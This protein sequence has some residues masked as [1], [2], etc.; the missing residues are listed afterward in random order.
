VTKKELGQLFYLERE[1]KFLE[2]QL[3]EIESKSTISSSIAGGATGQNNIT[4]KVGNIATKLADYQTLICLTIEKLYHQKNMTEKYIE[5]LDDCQLRL[6][7][8]M[9]FIKFY[10][11]GK[12]AH[13]IRANGE[14]TPR[15]IVERF[16]EEVNDVGT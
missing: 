4:D 7:L 2:E 16:F 14:S 1:I 6:I 3:K 15:M 10:S 5:S 11:W 12:I 8:R 9:R 13:A